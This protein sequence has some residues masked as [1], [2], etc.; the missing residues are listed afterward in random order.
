MVVDPNV[1]HDRLPGGRAAFTGAHDQPGGLPAPEV[2]AEGLGGIEGGQEPVGEV[3]RWGFISHQM[4]ARRDL[5]A[6]HPRPSRSRPP[7]CTRRYR[8]SGASLR[9]RLEGHPGEVAGCSARR[10]RHGGTKE[11]RDVL[12]I[13]VETSAGA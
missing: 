7:P 9:R 12:R 4:E 1:D 3:V 10:L 11:A 6:S 13:E 5:A 2:A 8:S